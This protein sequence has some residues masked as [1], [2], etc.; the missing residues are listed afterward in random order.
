M[1]RQKIKISEEKYRSF[2]LA[3]RDIHKKLKGTKKNR[4]A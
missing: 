3:K 1:S 2:S 4:K